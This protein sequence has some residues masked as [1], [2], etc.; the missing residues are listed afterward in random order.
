VYWYPDTAAWWPS[1]VALSSCGWQERHVKTEKS[2]LV[3][4]HCEQV[5]HR[6]LCV[7]E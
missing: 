5:V 7:P 1:V 2:L 6:P 3:V 4:W